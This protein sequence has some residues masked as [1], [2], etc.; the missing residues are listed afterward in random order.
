MYDDDSTRLTPAQR[1][2]GW[3][4]LGFALFSAWQ[5]Y[6]NHGNPAAYGGSVVMLALGIAIARDS[7]IALRVYQV[8]MV[9]GALGL[10]V[11]YA[12]TKNP[13]ILL[14]AGPGLLAFGL[15]MF[16]R[17]GPL[18]FAL[19]CGF[20]LVNFFMGVFMGG[21]SK[22]MPPP[23]ILAT[24]PIAEAPIPSTPAPS[25]P[26]P[27]A[28]PRGPPVNNVVVAKGTPL[29]AAAAQAQAD[30]EARKREYS[31]ESRSPD[32]SATLVQSYLGNERC[33]VACKNAGDKE[34]WS[35][36]VCLAKRIDLRFLSNDCERV[37]VMHQ[38]PKPQRRWQL[39]E[40]AHVYKRGAE[41]DWTVQAGGMFR[42]ESAMRRNGSSYYWL[43]G[44]LNVPGNPPKYT[45][46]GKG[47]AYETID[48]KSYVMPLVPQK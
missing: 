26:V 27:T 31:W 6:K 5:I 14:L 10:A 23:D 33:Q 20:L 2:G 3:L 35:S 28:A 38:I 42:E 36:E 41:P 32:E 47:V 15:L 13:N 4:T 24:K 45:P 12:A 30:E 7:A 1:F 44:A 19:A 43:G 11:V 17:P 40:V 37:I 8:L 25:L 48:G 34:V 16:G 39:L 22:D 18:S 9:V 46:D 21:A 29:D